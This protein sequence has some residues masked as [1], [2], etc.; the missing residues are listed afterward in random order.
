MLFSFVFVSPLFTLSIKP[1]VSHKELLVVT[2]TQGWA[3]SWVTGFMLDFLKLAISSFGVWD[4]WP[5]T[6]RVFT[7]QMYEYMHICISKYKNKELLVFL[8]SPVSG[9]LALPAGNTAWRPAG[10][11]APAASSLAAVI[12]AEE[13]SVRAAAVVTVHLMPAAGCPNLTQWVHAVT[14]PKLH[15]DSVLLQLAWTHTYSSHFN[16][17]W[18]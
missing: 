12:G 17:V 1:G 14:L 8:S 2:K 16:Y 10:P 9:S 6:H 5:D 13:L 3:R 4:Q 15:T 7:V 11:G 18:C